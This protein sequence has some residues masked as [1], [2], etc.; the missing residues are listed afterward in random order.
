MLEAALI[1]HLLNNLGTE[2]SNNN[3]N[4][5]KQSLLP[6]DLQTWN[7]TKSVK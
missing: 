1:N 7:N 3:N 6:D 4:K 5:K 2:N